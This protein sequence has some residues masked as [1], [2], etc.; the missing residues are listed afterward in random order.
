MRSAEQGDRELVRDGRLALEGALLVERGR[1]AG[2]AFDSLLCVP[3]REAWA[4]DLGL[5]GLEPTILPES[6]IARIAGYPF[7]RGVLGFAR[8]PESRPCASLAEAAAVSNRPELILA[9]PEAIDPANLGAAFRSA[10]ALGCSALLLGPGGPDPLC[11]R[12]LRASMGASLTLPWARMA[13]P[14]ALAAFIGAGYAAAACVLEPDAFDLRDF[15][16]PRRLI[17]MMG[18]EAFGLSPAWREACSLAL[19]LPMLGGADSLNI[20]AAVAIF[21]HSLRSD[22]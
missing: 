8:R 17:V 21:L 22:K 13:G 3:A 15:R 11:R 10:A 16:R 18:N 7:H 14:E 19:T 4:R 1:A 20:A 12:S 9:L 5:R 2:L 6:E